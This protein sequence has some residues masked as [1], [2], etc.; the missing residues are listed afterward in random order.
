MADNNYK[1]C[2]LLLYVIYYVLNMVLQNKDRIFLFKSSIMVL[3]FLIS[4]INE[5]LSSP[6]YEMSYAPARNRFHI[7]N[8]YCM[9]MIIYH[10]PFSLI[11]F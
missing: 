7:S 1:T 10:L 6:V 11:N 2:A 3:Q 4:K 8:I 5:G 9:N